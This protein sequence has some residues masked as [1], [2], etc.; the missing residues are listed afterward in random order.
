MHTFL[1]A[2]ELIAPVQQ[3]IY[4]HVSINCFFCCS[5]VFVEFC[6]WKKKSPQITKTKYLY[7]HNSKIFIQL[8]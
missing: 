8:Q 4:G 7:N 6:G 2:A 1:Q 5:F 3:T